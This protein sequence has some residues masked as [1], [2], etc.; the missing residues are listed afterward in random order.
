[1]PVRYDEVAAGVRFE[2]QAGSISVGALLRRDPDA[3]RLYEAGFNANVVYPLSATG[4]LTL[5]TARQLPDFV[6]GADA[7]ELVFIGLRLS[8]R[9]ASTPVGNRARPTLQVIGGG[10]V[11]AVRVRA[12]GAQRVEVMADFTGWESV[13]LVPD[14]DLFSRDFEIPPG[15]HRV[16]VRIDGG[17][18][19]PAANTPAVDDDLG[20]R[21][22]LI[23]VP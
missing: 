12:S 7:A 15:T 5:A 8:R 16:A 14:G 10:G 9:A 3:E 11:R 22:G 13:A 21:V 2:R 23:V 17:A 1:V 6:R 4:A 20:G 18:W 19:I